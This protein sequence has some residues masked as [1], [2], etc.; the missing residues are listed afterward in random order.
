HDQ[1]VVIIVGHVGEMAEQMCARVHA[2]D[3]PGVF[4]VD[5]FASAAG[6]LN[7]KLEIRFDLGDIQ[8]PI[9]ITDHIVRKIGLELD[10]GE[11]DILQPAFV[12][13][14]L[15]DVHVH[16]PNIRIGS[17]NFGARNKATIDVTAGV[18]RGGTLAI[19]NHRKSHV[20]IY[21]RQIGTE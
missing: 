7:L 9:E 8:Q 19:K 1:L 11:V 15:A 3:Q 2:V 6:R 14:E 5:G 20:Q 10:G 12:L 13:S 4:V 21:A 16:F 17:K 18:G